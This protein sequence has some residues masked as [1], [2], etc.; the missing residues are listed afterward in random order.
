M[1][2]IIAITMLALGIVVHAQATVTLPAATSFSV[3]L[4]WT[5]SVSCSAATPCTYQIYRIAGS[6]PATLPGT[7]GWT[8]LPPTASQAVTATD[9]TVAAGATYSYVAETVQG[10]ANSG[11]SN[12]ITVAIPNVPAAP[13]NL[14][15]SGL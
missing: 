2:R 12:C 15:G 14:V 4:T 10:T 11:P 3:V 13:T 5:A 8:A 7:S 9:S 6:C 1:K